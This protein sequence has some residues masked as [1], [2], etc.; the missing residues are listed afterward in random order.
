MPTETD[1]F[2]SALI[3]IEQLRD[4]RVRSLTWNF[5][6]HIRAEMYL[7]IYEAIVQKGG[8][9][10]KNNALKDVSYFKP[11]NRDKAIK[12]AINKLIK[13]GIITPPKNWNS[14]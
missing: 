8:I 13:L 7:T 11:S 12:S 14:E 2:A 5:L 1:T 3:D 10:S 4:Y 6:P 9:Y